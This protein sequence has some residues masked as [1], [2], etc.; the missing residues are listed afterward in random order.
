[1]LSTLP[2]TLTRIFF[3]T[4]SHPFLSVDT[5]F[6]QI[7]PRRLWSPN[8]QFQV[9]LRTIWI[10]YISIIRVALQPLLDLH[11]S[12]AWLTHHWSITSTSC[13]GF[14]Y[15]HDVALSPASVWRFCTSKM[16]TMTSTTKRIQ[17]RIFITRTSTNI[18]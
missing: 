12:T 8:P 15:A 17:R 4:P 11:F 10:P 14:T 2:P 1:M 18:K 16:Y 13:S 6:Y 9:F 3:N 5:Y 7:R